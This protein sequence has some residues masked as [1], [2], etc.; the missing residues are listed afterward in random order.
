M[1]PP[2]VAMA[3]AVVAGATSEAGS[4]PAHAVTTASAVS[5]VIVVRLTRVFYRLAR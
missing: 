1:A 5:T 2:V 3:G 4:C